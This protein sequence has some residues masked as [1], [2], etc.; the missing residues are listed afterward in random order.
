[1][2]TKIYDISVDIEDEKAFI[3]LIFRDRNG[4][5]HSIDLGIYK[6][7]TPSDYVKK[8]LKL[9]E[10]PFSDYSFDSLKSLDK[11]IQK[12]GINFKTNYDLRFSK[13]GNAYI[14]ERID[15]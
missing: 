1:M 2:I 4:G 9:I 10:Y 13:S 6:D 12:S 5:F 7:I 3:D 11:P 14:K 15:S 8:T